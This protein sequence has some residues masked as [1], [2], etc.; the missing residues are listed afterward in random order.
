MKTA[1]YN[2]EG[3]SFRDLLTAAV[4][5]QR[6]ARVVTSWPL[7]AEESKQLAEA[8]LAIAKSQRISNELGLTRDN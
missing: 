2:V 6:A 3:T 1:Q 5:Y 4:T 8:D 7:T